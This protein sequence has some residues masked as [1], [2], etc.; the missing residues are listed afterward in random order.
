L[1]SSPAIWSISWSVSESLPHPLPEG[2]PAADH[3]C[4]YPEKVDVEVDGEQISE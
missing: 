4:F 2:L 3:L 1:S